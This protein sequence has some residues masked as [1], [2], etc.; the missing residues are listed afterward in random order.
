MQGKGDAHPAFKTK[1]QQESLLNMKTLEKA[2][3]V[4]FSPAGNGPC[5]GYRKPGRPYQWLKYRQVK[6][7]CST[8]LYWTNTVKM[9]RDSHFLHFLSMKVSDRAE[10]LGSGLLHRGLKPNPNT[11]VGVFAQNRP[12]VRANVAWRL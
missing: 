1:H 2:Q 12:E 9:N 4:R 10:H 3:D 8:L 11:F 7:A 5:L 6:T